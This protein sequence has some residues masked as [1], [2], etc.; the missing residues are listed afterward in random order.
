MPKFSLE[1]GRF[2]CDYRHEGTENRTE[3]IV[4]KFLTKSLTARFERFS[5]DPSFHNMNEVGPHRASMGVKL[6]N[7]AD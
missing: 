5:F 4:P 2:R 7:D 1:F 6:G 3:E